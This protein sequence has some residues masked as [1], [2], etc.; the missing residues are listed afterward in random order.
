MNGGIEPI[1]SIEVIEREEFEEFKKRMEDFVHYQ[2]EYN[3]KVFKL[4]EE[5]INEK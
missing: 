5:I 3:E 2:R 4:I 1:D